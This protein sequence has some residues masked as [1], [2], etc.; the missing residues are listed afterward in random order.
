M[1]KYALVCEAGHGFETWFRSSDEYDRQRKRHLVECPACGS[2]EIEKQ[3]MKPQVARTDR[4]RSRPAAG[5]PVAAPEQ[6]TPVAMMSPQE[7]FL[8]EKLKEL[9][10]HVTKNAD[11]VGEKFPELARQMHYEEIEQRS[12]YGEAKPDEVKELIDE[13]VAVQP[14]PTL[15]EEKN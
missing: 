15:P 4:G 1:I 7:Q 10:E 9:R 11:Y 12:I 3:I 13:G 2:L 5:A 8:R 14:L 6:P